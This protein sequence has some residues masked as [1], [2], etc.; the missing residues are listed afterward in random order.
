[1]KDPDRI[2]ALELAITN[3]MRE[4]KFYLKHADRTK[5]PLGRAMFQQLAEDEREHYERLKEMEERWK[6]TFPETVPAEIGQSDLRK[7]LKQLV[8]AIEPV[9]I[10]DENELQAIR[11][12]L[13]FEAR[14]VAHYTTLRDLV[15]DPKEKAFFGLLAEMEQEHYRI[16]KET[17]EYLTAPGS[18]SD[19]SR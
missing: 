14:G 17:K 16:L 2:K 12:A 18:W 19:T 3:E 15:T 11:T 8:D 9:P 6:D 1:M 10:S 5:N 13:A 4:R 7:T